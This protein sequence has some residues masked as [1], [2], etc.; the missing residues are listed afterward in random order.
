M[1]EEAMP[2]RKEGMKHL[3]RSVAWDLRNEAVRDGKLDSLL[4]QRLDALEGKL[5]ADH[6]AQAPEWYN[7]NLKYKTCVPQLLKDADSARAQ[8]YDSNSVLC[9]SLAAQ[10][11]QQGPPGAE[12]EASACGPAPAT[13]GRGGGELAGSSNEVTALHS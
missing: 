5:V 13:G 3:A 4:A 10:R 8:I 12:G 11:G 9:K 7:D 6:S 1:V 2:S